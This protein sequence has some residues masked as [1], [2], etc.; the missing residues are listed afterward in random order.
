[1]LTIKKNNNNNKKKTMRY[2][3]DGVSIFIKGVIA[4]I[5]SALP[6]KWL[7]NRPILQEQQPITT[8]TKKIVGN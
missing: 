5:P 6:L 2:H 1:V 3:R 8:T 7:S 4:N